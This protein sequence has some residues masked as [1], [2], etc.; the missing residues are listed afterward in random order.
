MSPRRKAS[1]NSL[2]SSWD[3]GD[4]AI[5]KLRLMFVDMLQEGRIALG[6]GIHRPVFLKQHGGAYGQLEIRDWKELSDDQKNRLGHLVGVF[7]GPKTYRAWVRFSS[8]TVPT[9]PDLNSTCGIAIKLFDVE[10][11]R[12]NQEDTT[13]DFLLQNHDVFLVD[14]AEQMC[15]FTAAGAIGSKG[16]I[17][18]YM[19]ANPMTA[20]IFQEMKKKVL[21]VLTIPYWSVLPY[22]FGEDRYVKY[23]LSPETPPSGSVPDEADYLGRDLSRRLL[24]G[25]ARFRF[26]VQPLVGGM[27]LDKATVRWDE[28]VSPPIWVATLVLPQ[29][30]LLVLGQAAYV[31]NLSFDPWRT[32]T[33]HEPAKESSLN[34]AR[35]RVYPASAD[36]RR[37][38]TG[39]PLDEPSDP[40]PPGLPGAP[41]EQAIAR[42][43]IHPAIGIARVGNS[44]GGWFYGP[45]VPD[46]LPEE[47]YRDEGGAL[48]RQAAR[49]RIYGLTADGRVVEEL[50][51]EN[52]EITWQVHLANKKA[53]WHEFHLAQ[54]IP[55]AASAHQSGLR[56]QVECD[57]SRLIIDAGS[58]EIPASR[59]GSGRPV[60]CAGSFMN[61][62]VYLGELR[63]DAEGRLV[64]LGGHGKAGSPVDAPLTTFAN[65]EGW[66]D[67]TSDGPV[68]ATVT[69]GERQLRVD[70]AWVVVAPPNYAPMQKSV[71]TMWD[72]M[73]DI[74]I[75]AHA[76]AAPSRPSFVDDILPIFQRLS[77]LQ[78]VNAGYAAT[79]GWN[80]ELNFEDPELC[81]RM[82]STDPTHRDFRRGLAHQFRSWD[83]DSWSPIPWPWLYGDAMS[84]PPAKTPRQ[85][86]TITDT[87]R[88]MLQQ[89]VEGDFV[90]DYA[91]YKRRRTLE[92]FPP[93]GQRDA[94]DRG[95]LDFCLAD[96]FHPGCEMT[97]IVRDPR[98]YM[99]P[100]RFR[101]ADPGAVEPTPAGH[102]ASDLDRPN[103]PLGPQF[104]GGITRWMAV[105]WQTDTASCRSGLTPSY[106]PYLPAFWPARV[107]N[108][109]LTHE[110]YAV[111]S[112]TGRK[113]GDR[114]AAFAKRQDWNRTLGGGGYM[115]QLA[116]MVEN[117]GAMGV[118]EPTKGPGLPGAPETVEV[119]TVGEPT[120]TMVDERPP[121]ERHPHR[122][123]PKTADKYRRYPRGLRS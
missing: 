115:A 39:V 27:P 3:C 35:Q 69:L 15:A 8:D 37:H 108:Q 90:D 81:E 107:P 92:D 78:W 50:T 99:A 68:T 70:P 95:A 32:L 28:N 25:E 97:W 47:S 54:D 121:H 63:T 6:E 76:L 29:Q 80:G 71:R 110:D 73:R 34:L 51:A 91:D 62:E 88:S 31:E 74:A 40:R 102:L 85:H 42:A 24:A 18:E 21:S 109:V 55:E 112:D 64:V 9:Q 93:S 72:L 16:A 77:R 1:T 7:A 59:C 45:E 118:V 58:K 83:Q 49:F 75:K 60:R 38:A 122:F 104:P 67:D 65:N 117:F 14:D 120:T 11:V 100:Y 19:K 17:Q 5:G 79:F 101:Q 36:T 52:A 66:Y 26:M 43:A 106:D 116:S 30:D 22:R 10:G 53:A 2:Q 86:T 23:K 84:I 111:A 113:L 13:V 89:W 94:L 33:V 48:K 61:E 20:L 98:M 44:P 96:A 57:R 123:D 12:G 46:P 56:N 119:E 4:D 105:P 114:L 82:A 41:P 87:Q 103:G